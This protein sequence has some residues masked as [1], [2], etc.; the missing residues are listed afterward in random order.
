MN[1]EYLRIE[2][3]HDHIKI[4]SLGEWTL[5]HEPQISRALKKIIPNKKIIWDLSGIELFDSSGVMLFSTYFEQFKKSCE[6]EIVG[7]TPEQ[8]RMYLLLQK[9]RVTESI[10]IRH[11]NFFERIGKN[12][13]ASYSEFVQYLEFSGHV[14]S[15][16]LYYLKY[17]KNFRYKE[18]IYHIRLSGMNAVLIIALTSFLVGLVISYQSAVQLAKFG[19]DLFIVDM[20]SISITRELGPLVTAIVVAGRSGSAYTAQ[21]GAMKITEEI[22]AMRTMGFDPFYFLVLPRVIALMIALPLLIFLADMI[23]IFGSMFAAS[24]ELNISYAQ[25]IDRLQEALEAKHFWIGIVKGPFFAVLIGMIGCFRGFQ[26][27]ND[28]ESIG[29]QTT[30][31]VVNSIF[32][33]IACDAI[34]S[35]ILTEWDI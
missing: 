6:V 33:V 3:N 1:E 14:V 35:V 26:V 17:P 31:S 8:E 21:I 16:F 34:F 10:P 24:L 27:T 9:N 2:Q 15:A 25:F 20:A 22:S 7:Y 18:I 12:A 30:A 4:V 28:T 11:E 29:A 32:F 19:A 23:G 5:Y 13:A